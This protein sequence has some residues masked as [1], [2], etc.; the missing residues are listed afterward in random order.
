MRR[1]QEP[2]LSSGVFVRFSSAFLGLPR[3][4]KPCLFVACDFFPDSL[5]LL[6]GAQILKNIMSGVKTKINP[7]YVIM[8]Q[9][10]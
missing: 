9:D 10:L 4:P 8:V 5:Y 7:K 3:I 2:E 6:L 1:P